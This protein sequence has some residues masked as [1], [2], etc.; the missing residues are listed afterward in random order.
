MKWRLHGIV[1][2]IPDDFG[3]ERWA[4][5]ECIDDYLAFQPR[6]EWEEGRMTGKLVKEYAGFAY[7]P[8]K[9]G[10]ACGGKFAGRSS[11]R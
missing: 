10:L 11:L 8:T 2:V 7:H 4:R 6:S 3:L 1:T 5:F 9:N